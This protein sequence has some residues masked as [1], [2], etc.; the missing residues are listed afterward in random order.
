METERQE[1]KVQSEM[2]DKDFQTL[3]EE[4]FQWWHLL[5]DLT[6][7]RHIFEEARDTASAKMEA[8]DRSIQS[9]KNHNI[10][11]DVFY[12][13]YNGP[14]GTINGF[15]MGQLPAST[16]PIEWNEINAGFGETALLLNTLAGMIGMDFEGYKI[17][18]LGNFS[19]IIRTNTL[20]MEY[21]L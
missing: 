1:L 11:N 21:F 19:K 2:L 15:R 13:W 3:V 7:D 17:V 20:R 9:I 10:L 18:P 8:I 4:E 5:N 6:L 12:I 16:C 14:F